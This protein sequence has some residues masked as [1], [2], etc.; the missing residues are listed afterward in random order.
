MS[1]HPSDPPA[2][3]P[4][5]RPSASSDRAERSQSASGAGRTNRLA[6]ASSP[7]LRQHAHNPVDWYPWGPEALERS[8]K[9]DKP[10]FLSIGYAAC[11]WCHV[12]ERESFE[13]TEI[14]A[15]LNEHFVNIKVDREERPDL[16]DIYMAAVQMIAGQGGWPMSVFLT[17]E[18]TPFFAG[19]YFP[20]DDRYGRPGF[21]RLLRGLAEA[22]R[23]R[24]DD[25]EKG[26][27]QV[28]SALRAFAVTPE[29]ESGPNRGSWDR[30][31]AA[32][33]SSFDDEFGGFGDAPKFP[34]SL[35]VQILL[36]EHARS[37]DG[38]LLRMAEETLDAMARGGLYDHL[39]GGFHRY[40]T[41]AKWLVPH[42]EKMLYDQ[43]LLVLAYAEAFQVTRSPLYERVLR[44]TCDYVLRD[45]TAPDGAFYSTED[46]DSE[47][48][49]GR[50]Y[51]WSASE[52]ASLLGDEAPLFSR[53]YDVT[54]EGNWEG[55]TI[56][57]R[58]RDAEA[59]GVE[60]GVS[61]DQ[62]EDRLARC[63]E[64]LFASRS[65]RVR[66]ARDEKILTA[67]N[68]LMIRALSRA[69]RVL[70]EPRFSQ[71]AEQASRFV[72]DKMI[73]AGRLHRVAM[74]GVVSVPAYLEDHVNL[75][76]GLVE[77][78]E[79]TFE[80]DWLSAAA[81]VIDL[82]VPLFADD[83]GGFFLTAE[84][85]TDLIVRMKMGQDGSVPSGNSMAAETLLRLGR[86]L[87]REDLE[88][89]GEGTLRAFAAYLEK[90]PEGLHQMLLALDILEGPRREIV[91][92]GGPG[93]DLDAMRRIV[94]R[95]FLPRTVLCHGK[96][97][98]HSELA[99]GKESIDGRATAYVCQ[100]FV[101]GA[102]TTDPEE[103]AGI[104][105]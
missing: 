66:P 61:A 19:T 102:P 74:D 86:L 18:R 101:C 62:I 63:R 55:T 50:Y 35:A 36:R 88:E 85:H 26:A 42:F 52:V 27:D 51:V 80:P 5:D 76:S 82:A 37:G 23:T 68:G 10:I 41:D 57:Q 75:A 78:Y 49:E 60:Y 24:R 81:T 71:A 20:P 32:L 9:E 98:E 79:A 73:V 30:A 103:L 38:E 94:D 13:D 90:M 99:R 59:L 93:P 56:L 22:Y 70:D 40:A 15:F 104:L 7:Y 31:V 45:L 46:A 87:G 84:D 29:S 83:A 105:A 69:A 1:P 34:H 11:H 96:G 54:P 95:T 25:I 4:S 3:H 53:A 65:H 21:R 44:G 92:A 2:G 91:L 43:A 12:M 47:G 58:V 77:L 100:D 48:E 97:L 89:R 8:S 67:W 33:R 64:T 14:A 17:P 28:M 16:D 39:G 6:A 72:L